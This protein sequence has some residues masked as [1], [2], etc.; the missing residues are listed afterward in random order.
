[1]SFSLTGVATFTPKNGVLDF[2]DVTIT[3]HTNVSF[4]LRQYLSKLNCV[5]EIQ[6]EGISLEKIDSGIRKKM[7]APTKSDY[8][9]VKA[10]GGTAKLKIPITN[11][12][13]NGSRKIFCFLTFTAHYFDLSGKGNYTITLNDKIEGHLKKNSLLE[14]FSGVDLEEDPVEISFIVNQVQVSI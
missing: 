12:N 1:M 10:N 5:K 2:V 3:N 11:A 7:R 6:L 13:P 4:Y 8:F 9:T 14:I